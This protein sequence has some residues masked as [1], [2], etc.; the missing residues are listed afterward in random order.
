MERKKV[1]MKWYC[2]KCG[3]IMESKSTV[4]HETERRYIVNCNCTES[5]ETDAEAEKFQDNH[6]MR[7][8]TNGKVED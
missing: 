3:S 1:E 8:S 6:W 2:K 4:V 5:M 7:L